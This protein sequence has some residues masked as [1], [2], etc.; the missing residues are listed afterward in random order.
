MWKNWL[1]T[2]EKVLDASQ[3]NIYK[4]RATSPESWQQGGVET[5]ECQKDSVAPSIVK[6]GAP[7][8]GMTRINAYP[9]TPK[10]KNAA[11][12][13]AN[14][15]RDQF[16]GDLQVNA[17]R[18]YCKDL[19]DYHWTVWAKEED[20]TRSGGSALAPRFKGEGEYNESTWKQVRG[21][22]KNGVECPKCSA[23]KTVACVSDLNLYKPDITLE[24][25]DEI[26]KEV[27]RENRTN[28]HK[29]RAEAYMEKVGIE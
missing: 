8:D 18:V 16:D 17:R 14:A 23:P 28:P 11:H 2:A 13:K 12:K 9:D 19:G 4:M 5:G 10:G 22:S 7:L 27:R 24:E 15:L 1:E 6:K 25:V 29:E 26:P 21:K 20:I 3:V